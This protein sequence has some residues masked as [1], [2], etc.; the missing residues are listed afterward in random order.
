MKC[1][2][3]L[4]PTPYPD[5][6]FYSVVARYH[7][8]SRNLL[9]SQTLEDLFNSANISSKVVLPNCL[10]ALTDKLI[11]GSHITSNNIIDGHT[12]FPLFC[13]FVPLERNFKIIEAM[14]SKQHHASTIAGIQ[15]NKIPTIHKYFKYCPECIITDEKMFGESYWHRTHQVFGVT[16]CPVHQIK[17]MESEVS[18]TDKSC[19]A[20]SIS[21]EKVPD[22]LDKEISCHY[23]DIAMNVFQLLNE[24]IPVNSFEDLTYRYKYYLKQKQLA[25]F[26]GTV[27]E[28]KLM[29]EFVHYYG[30]T[31]LKEI[32]CEVNNRNNWLN[33][34]LKPNKIVH[35]LRHI[36]LIQFL[37]LTPLEFF[38]SEIK[39]IYPFGQG[40]WICFNGASNH[41]LEPVITRCEVKRGTNSSVKLVGTFICECG[42]TYSKKGLEKYVPDK[43]KIGLIKSYGEVWEKKLISLRSIEKKSIKEIASILKVTP[44]TVMRNLQKLDVNKDEN[45]FKTSEKFANNLEMYRKKWLAIV[46]AY[47]NKKITEIRNL[48]EKEYI[49]LY[50]NDKEWLINNSPLPSKHTINHKQS[51]WK[52]RD[53]EYSSNVLK[54]VNELLNKEGRP[55]RLTVCS[56]GKGMGIY[57][58]L[59]YGAAKLPK[60]IAKINSFVE[61]DEE[62]QIRRIRWAVKQLYKDGKN[63]TFSKVR[64]KSSIPTK[65]LNKKLNKEIEAQIQKLFT[66]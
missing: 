15:Q 1:K 26:N 54:A 61:T 63:V 41:Y 24:K 29:K 36:L 47:P 16:I 19:R 33:L 14:E 2:L 43:Y 10:K 53:D 13:P 38:K 46:K 20:L 49:W 62:Y 18:T 64:K 51:V 59:L 65:Y 27:K 17:L 35:P 23:R 4:F 21:I 40:P 56:L 32:K 55:I 3:P 37:G 57:H 7:I 50:R 44:L 39:E 31:F 52:N 8:R 30:E 45:H 25:T 58:I 12:L 60:T 28:S 66:K 48:A 42:F 34:I 22:I 11:E 5:E 9:F 6:L